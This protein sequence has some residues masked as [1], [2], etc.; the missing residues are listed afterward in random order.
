MIVTPRQQLLNPISQIPL[1]ARGRLARFKTPDHVVL[2]DVD[3]QSQKTAVTP[4]V[5]F[6]G[7]EIRSWRSTCRC[8][9]LST[10][11]RFVSSNFKEIVKEIFQRG[12][13]GFFFSLFLWDRGGRGLVRFRTRTCCC[14]LRTGFVSDQLLYSGFVEC[15]EVVQI[16]PH[17]AHETEVP[18]VA[19]KY[20]FSF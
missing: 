8:T 18:K 17:L 10:S 11:R 6:V 1:P 12:G 4:R 16:C 14:F 15:A 2:E 9:F 3:G 20:F 5:Q 7:Q 13:R 19:I